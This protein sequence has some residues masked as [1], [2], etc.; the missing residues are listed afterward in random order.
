MFKVEPVRSPELHRDVCA[1]LGCEYFDGTFA[2]LV[3]EMN[4]DFSAIVS[5][6]GLCQFTLDPAEAVVKSI[7]WTP[8][9]ADDEAITVMLRAVMSFCHRAEIPSIMITD[10]AAPEDYIKSAGFRQA[11]GEWRIDLKKFYTS[12]CHYNG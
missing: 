2:F 3:G 8:D 5:V 9:H 4:E 6:F 1:H 12:P 10:G 11:D 7:S